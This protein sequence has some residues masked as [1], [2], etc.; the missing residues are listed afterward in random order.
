MKRVPLIATIIVLG[1]MAVMV[2]LGLWQLARADEKATLL[3]H[4]E[5]AL[6]LPALAPWPESGEGDHLVRRAMDFRQ[7]AVDCARVSRIDA[8]SGRNA[9]GE[10][11]WA[12]IAHCET[13]QGYRMAE[14]VL[15][16][17]D[18]PQSPAWT[19]GRARGTFRLTG[20]YA[21]RVIAD[22]PLAGLGAN[23]R[24]DPADVPNNHLAYAVQWFLFALAAGVIYLL[25][26]RRR[27]RDALPS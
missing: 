5:R 14:V 11:G 7:T 4:Y 19:G 27:W 8:V 12:H 6:A 15:G 25:A 2:K 18:T 21:A 9:S 13:A 26:L 22:P 10:A 1:A 17:S 23:A 3:A 16:W 20:Q 24:P